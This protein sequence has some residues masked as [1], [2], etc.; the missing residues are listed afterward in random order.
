MIKNNSIKALIPAREGSK[1]IPSKNMSILNGKPLIQYTIQA[2]IESRSLDR[3]IVSTDHDEIASISKSLGAEV[4]FKRPADISEDVDTEF[5]LKHAINY[6]EDAEI[7]IAGAGSS[8]DEAFDP[9]IFN[10]DGITFGVLAFDDVAAQNFAATDDEP[11][12]APL[13]DDYS[14]EIASGYQSYFHP[15]SALSLNRFKK[16]ITDL[17]EAVD[18]VIVQVQTGTEDTHDP[19]ER[20]IKALRVARSAGATLVIGNQAHHVQAIEP[21]EE[22]KFIAYALGNFIFDQNIFNYPDLNNYYRQPS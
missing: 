18:V 14:D 5:V 12:T 7:K 3:I 21:L 11:G 22:G 2:A 20:S 8:L 17:A 1:G 15:A 13:D 16:L 19:S 4:P 10:I 6:L 9:I